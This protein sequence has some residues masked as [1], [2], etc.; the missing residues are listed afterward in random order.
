MSYINYGGYSFMNINRPAILRA[1]KELRQEGFIAKASVSRNEGDWMAHQL[2]ANR[3]SESRSDRGAVWMAT[4]EEN[5]TWPDDSGSW[6]N[7]FGSYN[8]LYIHVAGWTEDAITLA[9]TRDSAVGYSNQRWLSPAAM[10]AKVI[11]KFQLFGLAASAARDAQLSGHESTDYGVTLSPVT[12][13]GFMT[14]RDLENVRA[15][16]AVF[17]EL[18][19]QRVAEKAARDERDR[20]CVINRYA[21]VLCDQGIIRSRQPMT[22]AEFMEARQ[23]NIERDNPTDA[24]VTTMFRRAYAPAE[25]KDIKRAAEALAIERLQAMIQDIERAV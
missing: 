18:D 21:D 16:Q 2:E 22:T 6:N 9:R 23:S 11:E 19:R 12:Q 15:D 5:F 25:Q 14:D 3:R 7:R 24:L 1:F 20:Q 8:R 10:Q 13:W 4:V 17:A